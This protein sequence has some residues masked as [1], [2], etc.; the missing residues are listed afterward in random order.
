MAKINENFG[1][2]LKKLRLQARIGLREFARLINKQPS[3]YSNIETGKSAPPAD[4]KTLDVICDTL[5]LEKNCE[6]RNILF[7]LAAKEGKRI[8]ADIAQSIREFRG[9]PVLVRT[10]KNKKLSETKLLELTKY[11]KKNY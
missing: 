5:G 10:I 9:I 11:I 6:Q 4:S 7:D 8:P 2:Y 3:N 1:E